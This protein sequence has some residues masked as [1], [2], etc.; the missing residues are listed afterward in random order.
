MRKGAKP[1]GHPHTTRRR[2]FY[3]KLCLIL[4]FALLRITF[5]S[6]IFSRTLS[7]LRSFIRPFVIKVD[8]RKPH[9][10]CGDFPGTR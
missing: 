8:L 3:A 5:L 2:T 10:R 6:K 1:L 9:E 4:G 7:T